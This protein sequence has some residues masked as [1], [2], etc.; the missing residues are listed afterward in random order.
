MVRIALAVALLAAALAL[1]RLEELV[2]EGLGVP[3]GGELG[4]TLSVVFET[5]A[6]FAGAHV[7]S[8]LLRELFWGGIVRRALG[9]PPPALLRETATLVV[10]FGTL[11][12]VV[13]AVFRQSVVAF[14]TALGATG[15]VAAFGVR[16]L[17]ADVWTGIAIHLERPFRV[18][19]WVSFFDTQAGAMVGQVRQINWRTTHLLAENRNYLV[20]PNREIGDST[21]VNYWR[22][23]K[24][25][26][27]EV[28][29]RL[30][31]GVPAE[32]A[33][34]ILLGAVTA[35]TREPGF[36]ERPAPKVLVQELDEH[37]VE[38]VVRYW[39]TPW[40]GTSPT[41]A[42]DVVHCAILRHLRLAGITP[43]YDKLH[44]F[45]TP[46]PELHDTHPEAHLRVQRVLRMTELFAPLTD[47]EIERLVEAS[48]LRE[49]RAGATLIHEGDPGES[50]FVLLQGL[51]DVRV[52]PIA[53]GGGDPVRVARLEAGEFFG[54]MS[55]LTGEPR[56][57]TVEAATP[58]AA[59][60]VTREAIE[61]LMADRPEVGERLAD[62]VARR[63]LETER[64]RSEQ[65][66][67]DP[68]AQ[69]G[70]AAQLYA[71]MRAF[72]RGG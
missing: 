68:D 16:G 54:E 52:A 15:V 64:R 42:A 18:G 11:L 53:D 23:A 5:V 46:K 62:I 48:V 14:V 25:N 72:L 29:V 59:L 2:L 4:L 32:E 69:A 71:R 55:L 20:I 28:T 63:E 57:A 38:Y 47:A 70:L 1:W 10:Y 33:K 8:T 49:W 51:L 31:Y 7:V 67:N 6:W 3:V 61:A 37:G 39:I 30:D 27:F 44:A 41:T 34:R 22:P 17:V 13:H 50:M 56:R 45:Q 43:A 60:E 36:V 9:R 12:L 21:V 66:G 58:A 40:K 65:P 24:V 26:R 19:D 35:V